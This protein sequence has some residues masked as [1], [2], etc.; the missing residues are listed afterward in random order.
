MIELNELQIWLDGGKNRARKRCEQTIGR[1]R[2]CPA[3]TY[4]RERRR[5][6]QPLTPRSEPE[7]A[8]P[9]HPVYPKAGGDLN[10]STQHWGQL[11]I[12][13][14]DGLPNARPIAFSEPLRNQLS[15]NVIFFAALIPPRNL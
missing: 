10:R 3:P 14:D 4:R 7:M 6:S 15:H 9:V 11:A 2:Q 8:Y 13:N 5:V 1:M 12:N